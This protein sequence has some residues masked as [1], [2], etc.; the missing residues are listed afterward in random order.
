M[1]K[2]VNLTVNQTWYSFIKPIDILTYFGISFLINR[3]YKLNL[4]HEFKK[5]KQITKEEIRDVANEI[6]VFDK[7]NLFIYGNV[8]SDYRFDF[9]SKNI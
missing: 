7:T 3:H 9:S 1:K 2:I 5:L 6:F 4:S 8:D